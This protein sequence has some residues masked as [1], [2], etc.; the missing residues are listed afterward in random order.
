MTSE[1]ANFYLVQHNLSESQA[2]VTC[3]LDDRS[4]PRIASIKMLVGNVVM[5]HGVRAALN[6][7]Q[8]EHGS[9]PDETA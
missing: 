1:S 9:T 7:Y 8:E 4:L 5:L 6:H 3:K 2:Q